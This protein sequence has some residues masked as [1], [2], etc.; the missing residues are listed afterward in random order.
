MANGLDVDSVR[1]ANKGAVIVVVVAAQA[2][3]AVVGTA[4]SKRCFVKF[5]DLCPRLRDEREVRC[6]THPGI[7]HDP[8][9]RLVLATKTVD[10]A[11]G[12]LLF[13]AWL[14]L[15]WCNRVQ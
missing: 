15:L 13:T 11:A 3:R 8:E 7:A 9:Q 1:V 6:F 5:I 4:R 10:A 2:G 12:F 14:C